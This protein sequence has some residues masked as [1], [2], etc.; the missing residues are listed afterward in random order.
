VDEKR[1]VID[2]EIVD[3]GDGPRSGYEKYGRR[4]S[5]DGFRAKIARVALRAGAGLVEKALLLYYVMR[6]QATPLWAKTAIA[7]ALGYFIL[8]VDLIP[9]F[10]PVAGFTDDLGALVG[11]SEGAWEMQ[12][13]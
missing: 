2:P 13:P 7:G 11:D 12:G 3:D 5:D 1:D 4:F 9:D 6:D 10:I 8:P